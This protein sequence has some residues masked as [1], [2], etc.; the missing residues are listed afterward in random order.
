MAKA[1]CS[2]CVVVWLFLCSSPAVANDAEKPVRVAAASSL[3]FVLND[4]L[5]AYEQHTGN[6]APQVVYGSSGNLYRQIVQGAPFDVFLSADKTLI[7]KLQAE[8]R[9]QSAA[10][11]FGADQL[12]L[13]SSTGAPPDIANFRRRIFDNDSELFKVAIASPRHAPFG[14]AAQQALQSM[15]LWEPVQSRL[16]FAE[17]VSQAAQF[18]VSGA[19]QYAIISRS[20][21]LSPVLANAGSFALITEGY[22]PVLQSMVLISGGDDAR[23]FY[24]FLGESELAHDSLRRF[25]LR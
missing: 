7:N 13:Y 4:I 6:T 14:R 5:A 21:A 1:L 16:V 18:T 8:N 9:V 10:V 2:F 23:A 20:L 17:R 11:V 22:A 3:Q 19:S 15:G 12:V 25:G 24:D